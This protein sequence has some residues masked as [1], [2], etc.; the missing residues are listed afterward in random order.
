MGVADLTYEFSGRIKGAPFQMTGSG[1]NAQTGTTYTLLTS[2]N[3][4][5]ITLSNASAITVTVPAGLGQGFSCMLMQIGAGQV[6]LV[7]SSTTINSFG[8]LLSLAGQHASATLFA[9]AA[10]TLN[11]SGA[12]V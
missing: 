1:I 12:L 10:D 2:D 3:G 5:V 6:T 9:Y 8:S 7:A 4:K 11:L